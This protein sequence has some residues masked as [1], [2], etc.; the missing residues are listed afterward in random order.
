MRALSAYVAMRFKVRLAYRG[1]LLLA[2]LGDLVMT[3]VGL[4]IVA[5]IYH[6]VPTVLGWTRSEALLCWGM[7]ECALGVFWVVFHGLYNVNRQYILEADLDR[8]LLRPID[9]YLQILLDHVKLQDL[10]MLLLG[11]VIVAIGAET[12]TVDWGPVHYAMLPVFIASG[13]LIIGGVLTAVTA[14]GFRMH[15]Q[16]S[17]IGLAYQVTAYARY[18]LDFLP[19]PLAIFVTVVVPFAFAGFLPATFFMDRPDWAVW[20]WLQPL[21]GVACFAAGYTFWTVS[22]RRYTSSGS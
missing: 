4:F 14:L 2:V 11:L 1:D 21:V 5:A 18:P 16:G 7:G 15:H 3:V 8:V 22:L 19:T 13:A 9:P 20:A 12:G 17:A 10:P 6:R